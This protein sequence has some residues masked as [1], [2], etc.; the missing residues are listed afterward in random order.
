VALTERLDF[1]KQHLASPLMQN[2]MG[3]CL[4]L[5]QIGCLGLFALQA[6]ANLVWGSSR[7]YAIISLSNNRLDNL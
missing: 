5:R 1:P 4:T 3:H 7:F 6:C 2:R